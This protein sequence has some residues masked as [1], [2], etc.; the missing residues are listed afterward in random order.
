MKSI[1]DINPF[2]NEGVE[3]DVCT[4]GE[5]DYFFSIKH[6]FNQNIEKIASIE[7]AIKKLIN[8]EK[9][10]RMK[11]LF[12]TKLNNFSSRRFKNLDTVIDLRNK[13]V[14]MQNDTE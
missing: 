7:F 4:N 9:D 10:E 8:S 5:Y 12:Q 2:A 14:D 11:K 1:K 6:N 13:I 3:S